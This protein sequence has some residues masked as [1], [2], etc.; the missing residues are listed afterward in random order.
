MVRTE[1]QSLEGSRSRGTAYLADVQRSGRHFTYGGSYRDRS[2]GFQVPLGFVDR[3]DIRET[4][5]YGGYLWRPGRGPLVAVGPFVSAGADWNYDGQ[6]QDWYGQSELLLYFRSPMHLK[7]AHAESFERF[8]GLS[9]RKHSNRVSFYAAPSPRFV[10]S[11][12]VT[13]GL[14]PNYAPAGDRL[15][16]LATT[17]DAYVGVTVRPIQRLRFDE[18]YYYSR[19]GER[20]FT[21]HI[22]RTRVSFQFTRA[23]SVRAIADYT[24]YVPDPAA[25][26]GSLSKRLTSDLLFT[27]LVSPFTALYVGYT[28]RHQNLVLESGVRPI[29]SVTSDV[30]SLTARQGFVK[31]SVRFGL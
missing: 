6:R 27:Y 1:T 19:L 22:S 11:G 21:N 24:A 18:T 3:V 10:V 25:V 17:L 14:G 15:P 5:H 28:E 2:P 4:S 30:T 16:F 20:T 13:Q 26:S 29:L 12:S 7:V 23:L 8:S 31:L 9:F